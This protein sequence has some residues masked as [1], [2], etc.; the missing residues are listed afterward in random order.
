MERAL[1]LLI[2]KT[3][4]TDPAVVK[5]L[6]GDKY[7]E[8]PD[9]FPTAP[10]PLPRPS[11]YTNDRVKET[12]SYADQRLRSGR[13]ITPPNEPYI[14]LAREKAIKFLKTEEKEKKEKAAV[15]LQ[16]FEDLAGKNLTLRGIITEQDADWQTAIL[17]IRRLHF[18]TRYGDY[19]SMYLKEFKQGA[20]LHQTEGW[21]KFKQGHF[22]WT[23][24]AKNLTPEANQ[25]KHYME[26]PYPGVMDSEIENHLAVS[27]ACNAMGLKPDHV[28]DIIHGYAKR[29]GMAHSGLEQY[30]EKC[31]W[32]ALAGTLND[33][34]AALRCVIPNDDEW[35][36]E[37][38]KDCIR[39]YIKLMF[40][41]DHPS[42]IDGHPGSWTPSLYAVRMGL[43]FIK[44]KGGEVE[45][46]DEEGKTAEENEGKAA[47][48]EK[49]AN[50][51]PLYTKE[52]RQT[53]KAQRQKACRVEIFRQMRKMTSFHREE[54]G[55]RSSI[56]DKRK[57]PRERSD[58][59]GFQKRQRKC[60]EEA[61]RYST[62]A[63]TAIEKFNDEMGEIEDELVNYILQM[64]DEVGEEKNTTD[65]ETAEEKT[66]EETITK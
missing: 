46:E 24:M 41:S 56:Q 55:T 66:T 64:G 32:R 36:M 31:E 47:E 39:W 44:N 43:D 2:K 10:K 38:L 42:F 1:A 3:R 17:G 33:D 48:E 22:L 28:I 16:N 11:D 8:T 63:V 21:E 4:K 15:Y 61:I 49:Q 27:R 53:I 19:L 45:E 29:N 26:T 13:N 60:L 12:L 65:E 34:L 37:P 30:V 9:T 6:L 14:Q 35:L 25:W 40:Q 7:K 20:K 62:K 54:G 5:D 59:V 50:E 57:A 58:D 23:N 18:Y 52:I 51:K